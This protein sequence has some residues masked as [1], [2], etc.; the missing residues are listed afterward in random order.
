[1]T[2]KH[3]EDNYV[4]GTYKRAPFVLVEGSG[5]YV[6]D[7]QRN[8]YLDFASGI[9]VNA[10]GHGDPAIVEAVQSQVAALSHVSNLYTTAPQAELAMMLCET[11]FADKVFFSNS[12]AE[13]NEAALKFARRYSLSTHGPGKT[14]FVSF[15][16]AFHGRTMGALSLTSQKKYQ[17]PFRPLVPGVYHLAYNDIEAAKQTINEKT[18]AVF[19]EVVQWEDGVHVATNEFLHTLSELCDQYGAL[20]IVDEVQ[21]G[22]GRTGKLWAYEHSGIVP[23]I[24]TS[25]KALGGGLP[26]GAT[27]VSQKVA[28]A[29]QAGDHGSTFGGGPVACSAAL[30]VVERANDPELLAHI[31]EM[32]EL[33]RDRIIEINSPH[34]LGVSGL[35][36]MIGVELDIDAAPIYVAGNEKGL[37][38]LTAGPKML[39]LLPPYIVEE[40]HVDEFIEKLTPLLKP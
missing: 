19:V 10:F 4:L 6:T 8:N 14:E 11:S 17:D 26:I 9:A 33:I 30:T 29:V 21:T 31:T 37:L 38:I 28:D 34:V 40:Q 15:S 36:L 5:M 3:T 22:V 35:G 16:G 20:L 18:C 39:R 32:G 23:D 25:A 13:A 2:I 24:M 12:G 7:N 27:L 1:V